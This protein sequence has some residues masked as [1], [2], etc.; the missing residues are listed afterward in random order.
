MEAETRLAKKNCFL[1]YVIENVRDH[2][3]SF[4][5]FANLVGDYSI[6]FHFLLEVKANLETIS[7][8]IVALVI[9]SFLKLPRV[10]LSL[11]LSS[12]LS[13]SD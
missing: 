10:S 11:F 9:T 1:K 12:F 5:G 2:E 4:I 13:L 3:V 8:S 7:S 6:L